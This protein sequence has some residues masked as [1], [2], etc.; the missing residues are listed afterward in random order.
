MFA[1]I[2]QLV[3][4]A[5]DQHEGEKVLLKKNATVLIMKQYKKHYRGCDIN[6][7]ECKLDRYGANSYAHCG[8]NTGCIAPNG[9]WT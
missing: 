8:M 5:D 6:I 9:E 7:F 2:T 1:G 4:L 3:L